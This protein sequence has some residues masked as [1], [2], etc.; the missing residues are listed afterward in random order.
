MS[1]L[2]SMPSSLIKRADQILKIYENKEIKRDIKIQESI[3]FDE[4]EEKNVIEEYI[5]ELNP[6]EITPLEALNILYELKE[7][8]KK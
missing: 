6:L 1:K 7:K 8:I 4:L 3:N 5:K 2:A